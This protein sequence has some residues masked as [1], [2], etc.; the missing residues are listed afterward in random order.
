M[1]IQSIAA[2][3]GLAFGA[4][5]F[6]ADAP[7]PSAELVAARAEAGKACESEAK[8]MCAGKE[9]HEAM[10]CLNTMPEHLGASCKAAMDKLAKLSIAAKPPAK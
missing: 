3:V 5:A 1:K 4:T 7:A 6:A 8:M 2:C 10:M 9:G